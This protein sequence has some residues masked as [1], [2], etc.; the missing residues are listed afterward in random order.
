MNSIYSFGGAGSDWIDGSLIRNHASNVFIKYYLGGEFECSK[1]TYKENG[2][3]VLCPRGTY[4][5]TVGDQACELC[6]P[7]TE[8]P[9]EGSDH[10]Q[11]CKACDKGTFNPNFGAPYCIQC[12]PE[13]NCELFAT[14]VTE[15]YYDDGVLSTNTQPDNYEGDAEKVD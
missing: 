2:E 11:F 14:S 7:G 5:N 4:K 9:E 1:G 10:P 3:C 13:A 12:P 8:N 15:N 6:T